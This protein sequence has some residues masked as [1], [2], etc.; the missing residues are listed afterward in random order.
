MEKSDNE[1][2]PMGDQED[3]SREKQGVRYAQ[4]TNKTRGGSEKAGRGEF[5]P[6][7]KRANRRRASGTFR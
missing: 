1:A 7:R 3:R 6:M 5:E 2:R 4:L